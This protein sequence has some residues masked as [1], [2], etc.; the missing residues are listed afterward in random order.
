MKQERI[1]TPAGCARTVVEALIMNTTLSIDVNLIQKATALTGIDDRSALVN[2]AL[3]RLIAQQSS[4]VLASLGG[5][6]PGLDDAHR[7]R[8]K[9]CKKKLSQ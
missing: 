2:L 6:E 1:H 7:R 3:K 4:Y 5:S 9:I 8:N